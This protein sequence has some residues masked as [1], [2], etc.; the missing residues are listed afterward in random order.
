ME[1][2]CTT[3]HDESMPYRFESDSIRIEQYFRGSGC[4]AE[5]TLLTLYVHDCK[6]YCKRKPARVYT[7]QAVARTY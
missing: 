6:Y 7:R 2:F 5:D 1:Y 4:C 3:P